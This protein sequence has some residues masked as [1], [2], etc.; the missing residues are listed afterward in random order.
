ME[1]VNEHGLAVALLIADAETVSAPVDVGPQVGLGAA[2]LPRF[3]LDTCATAA[4]ALDA[5]FAAK[6]YDLGVPLHYIVGDRS[7]D[8]F[9]WERGPGGDERAVRIDGSA[10][11]VTNHL[12]H[13]HP[14]PTDL[15]ADNAET[16]LSY[17]RYRTLSE[18]GA[19][20]DLSLGS[21]RSALDAVAFDARN[22]TDYPIRTLWSSVFD[23]EAAT[24]TT[25][26]FLGDETDG[27]PR[28][29][30]ELEF[31]VPALQQV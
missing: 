14:D 15:P 25:R 6:Q 9:L 17:Q 30:P 3:L 2:Q 10:L 21:L 28:R 13:R 8:A 20:S 22:A 1:G 24:M 26:F 18:R 16:M 11:C 23:L 27:R 4:E 7:G 5:L 29:S 12:V 19:G 31:P